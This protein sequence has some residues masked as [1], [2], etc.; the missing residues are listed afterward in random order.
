MRIEL[1][2]IEKI[3]QYLMGTLS[4]QDKSAFEQQI[5]QHAAL[6]DQVDFQQQLLR[7]IQSLALKKSASVAY[8]TYKFRRLLIALSF[9][10]V[11][12]SA[13]LLSLYFIPKKSDS[14][15]NVNEPLQTAGSSETIAINDT[16][17]YVAEISLT[18]ENESGSTTV[19]HS[20]QKKTVVPADTGV[21]PVVTNQGTEQI[22]S[23][24]T[25]DERALI[26]TPDPVAAVES[27]DVL[28]EWVITQNTSKAELKKIGEEIQAADGGFKVREIRYKGDLLVHIA[29]TV[30]N[31]SGEVYYGS[32]ELGESGKVCI[33]FMNPGISAGWCGDDMNYRHDVDSTS[34][35]G[36][37]QG[38][39]NSWA[40]EA[41]NRLS[42]NRNQSELSVEAKPDKPKRKR[43]FK[44]IEKFY[45]G[46]KRAN[47]KE[48]R[49]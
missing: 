20:T 29:F 26:Q 37:L 32:P 8:A 44:Q 25:V 28:C 31:A 6:K 10:A 27:D 38:S 21:E 30:S 17:G 3:E 43:F 34:D 11:L 18:G 15:L 14:G 2:V 12:I 23:R 35:Q 7:G 22:E 45:S 16:S 9:A 42:E 47:T 39:V 33:R 41:K 49:R 36:M 13:L 5:Q 48:R 46:Q 1:S 4:P 40:I 24:N 19:I